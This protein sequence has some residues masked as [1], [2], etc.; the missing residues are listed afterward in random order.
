MTLVV[1]S[2]E[3]KYYATVLNLYASFNHI[4]E[5]KKKNLNIKS[6]L[7]FLGIKFYFLDGREKNVKAIGNSRRRV[8]PVW[9]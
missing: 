5:K 1:K 2:Q 7:T 9:F 6:V 3:I 4:P 8:S